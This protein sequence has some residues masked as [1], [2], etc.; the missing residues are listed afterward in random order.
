[1]I[2]K[3]TVTT[4]AAED[5]AGMGRVKLEAPTVWENSDESEDYYPSVGA[6]PLN[7]GDVVFVYIQDM[8]FA[9]PLILGRC[10]DNSFVTNAEDFEG[11]SIVFES[12]TGE[13]DDTKW[14]VAYVRGNSLIFLNSDGVNCKI[15]GTTIT[16]KTPKSE[17][18]VNDK[19]EVKILAAGETAAQ[20]VIFGNELYTQLD[21]LSKRVDAIVQAIGDTFSGAP[22][23]PMD[24][25]AT[26]K[27]GL[28]SMWTGKSESLKQETNENW[29]KIRNKSVTTAGKDS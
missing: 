11:Y 25:G 14:S 12:V 2:I 26:F 6:Q 18:T 13:G 9:N 17:T 24:G 10:W 3:A 1:M 28:T 27:T 4:N 23:A 16:V 20:P 15:D 22:V 5:P 21:T 7:V 8:D 29:D 19:G